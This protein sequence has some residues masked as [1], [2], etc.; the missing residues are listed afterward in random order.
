MTAFQDKKNQKLIPHSEHVLLE[1][2]AT[3]ATK[4]G[5]EITTR[6]QKEC[7]V[8]CQDYIPNIAA[9]LNKNQSS[10]DFKTSFLD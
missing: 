10:R 4:G 3:C 2:P 9:A 7:H 1:I 8:L 6:S 5:K